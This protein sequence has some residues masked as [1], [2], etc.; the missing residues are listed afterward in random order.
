MEAQAGL[1]LMLFAGLLGS[2]LFSLLLRR[3][4]YGFLGNALL[5]ILG[6]F[7]ESR[8]SWLSQWTFFLEIEEKYLNT[9]RP[10]GAIWEGLWPGF[11]AG[12]TF[13]LIF[14]VLKAMFY[15]PSTVHED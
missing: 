4:S 11:F 1:A 8:M 5:G 3:G 2:G 14:G 13:F 15:R 6:A 10:S 9:I 12:A 7:I